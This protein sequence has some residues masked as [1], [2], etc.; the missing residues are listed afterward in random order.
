MKHDL[1]SKQLSCSFCASVERDVEFL[2]EGDNAYI[3]DKCVIKAEK[4]VKENL[5]KTKTNNSNF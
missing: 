4:I 1:K 5:N 3:C 2:V